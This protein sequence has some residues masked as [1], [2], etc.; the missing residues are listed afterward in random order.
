VVLSGGGIK[1]FAAIPLFEFLE[2][3]QVPIDVLVGCSGGS[4]LSVLRAVG[5]STSD[6]LTQVIPLI[7]KT[8]FKTNKRALLALA[9][10]PYG[11][12]D[13]RSGFLKPA[14]LLGLFRDIL[15]DRRIEDLDQKLILQVTDFETGEGIGLEKGDLAGSLYASCALFP[16]FPPIEIDGRWLFDGGFSA[17]LPVL[18]A[19]KQNADVIIVVDFME[20]MHPDPKGL[21]EIM[22]HLVKVTSKSNM[23]QQMALAISVHHAEFVYFNVRFERNVAL[24]QTDKMPEVLEAGRRELDSV[25]RELMAAIQLKCE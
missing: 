17:P 24:W 12:L 5:Y 11:R 1:P 19:V 21:M 7:N 25:C 4:I 10:L 18:Q 6:I 20:K 2:G 22:A 14:P 16:L 13:R 9:N 8:L 15:G 3:K 23:A